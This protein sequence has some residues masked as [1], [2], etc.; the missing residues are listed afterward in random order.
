MG[1]PKRHFSQERRNRKI[2]DYF[3]K[4]A[5][6]CY[7]CGGAMTLDLNKHNT[8]EIEHLV[9]KSHRRVPGKFNEA[10]AGAAC[11]RYKADRPLHEVITELRRLKLCE[12]ANDR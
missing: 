12:L 2:R 6:E 4:Q 10:A 5:G 9:P 8:A 1:K 3:K 11:N 7:L